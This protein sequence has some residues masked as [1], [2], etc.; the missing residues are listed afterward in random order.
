MEDTTAHTTQ[1]SDS[2]GKESSSQAHATAVFKMNE[3]PLNE[4]ASETGQNVC[5]V[6]VPTE[7]E[8]QHRSRHFEAQL[9]QRWKDLI[10]WCDGNGRI[11]IPSKKGLY[12]R[13]GFHMGVLRSHLAKGAR[14]TVDHPE[15]MDVLALLLASEILLKEGNLNFEQGTTFEAFDFLS[16]KEFDKAVDVLPHDNLLKELTK[17][18]TKARNLLEAAL[19]V[20]RRD[21][22]NAG[23]SIESN[24]STTLSFEFI[25]S[26][27]GLVVRDL[28][29]QRRDSISFHFSPTVF[30][31]A[32]EGLARVAKQISVDVFVSSMVDG[33]VTLAA[34]LNDAQETALKTCSRVRSYGDVGDDDPYAI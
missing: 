5:A 30:H 24:R 16:K 14:S 34:A 29:P 21:S 1:D 10:D 2:P 8:G 13:F 15:H 33:V 31:I 11:G 27:H 22:T 25:Q 28:V 32:A 26:V 20:L 23:S 19:F 17:L 4:C 7:G 18:V 3:N 6:V 9:Q 12:E